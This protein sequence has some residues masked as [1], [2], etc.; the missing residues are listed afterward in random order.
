[1]RLCRERIPTVMHE[2]PVVTNNITRCFMSGGILGYAYAQGVSS[3]PVNYDYNLI[4]DRCVVA[5]NQG[6]AGA[7]RLCNQG[8]LKKSDPSPYV[9]ATNCLFACNKSVAVEGSGATATFWGRGEFVNCTIAGNSPAGKV[10]HLANQDA[11][12]CPANAE[13]CKLVN[14]I[15]SDN[16]DVPTYES[17]YGPITARNSIFPEAEAATYAGKGNLVGP[18]VFRGTGKT[19]YALKENSPGYGTGDASIW[20][21]KDVDL[22]GK[23][24]LNS[25]NSVDMGCYRS[26]P[27]FGL[28]ISFR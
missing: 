9:Y 7:M 19:P 22:V 21:L 16:G 17:T 1:M 8:A 26:H 25:K 18:A 15:I 27:V 28:V 13:V 6:R 2:E 4:L 20:T 5:N 24:R 23:R 11:A 14:T 12:T 3:W 10:F